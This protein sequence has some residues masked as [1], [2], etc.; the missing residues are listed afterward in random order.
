M[1]SPIN[2]EQ[3]L[4]TAEISMAN[5]RL[6]SAKAANL[7]RKQA[8]ALKPFHVSYHHYQDVQK[9]QHP[10]VEPRTGKEYCIYAWLPEGSIPILQAET[11]FL[12]NPLKG[13]GVDWPSDEIL[14]VGNRV[15]I[16]ARCRDTSFETL[17]FA[18]VTTG[19]RVLMGIHRSNG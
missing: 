9:G 2:P 11:D 7:I 6:L 18:G 19:L 17:A 4:A 5:P 8:A 15:S 14:T 12:I 13:D 10:A 3:S 1:P 16:C